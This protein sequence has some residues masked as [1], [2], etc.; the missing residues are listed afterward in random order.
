[1]PRPDHAGPP[2]KVVDHLIDVHE[3]NDTL[4]RLL[5]SG[6]GEKVSAQ[7]IRPV[8]YLTGDVGDGWQP[9]VWDGGDTVR[10]LTSADWDLTFA[11][12]GAYGGFTAFEGNV[13][14]TAE[15]PVNGL[16]LRRFDGT[17]VHLVD[18]GVG[19]SQAGLMGGFIEHDGALYFTAD[20]P[21]NG[22]E[23]RK[24]DGD[25]VTLVADIHKGPRDSQAG[26]FGGFIE[27]D[28]DLYFTA[29]DG[30]GFKL[31]RYDGT[32][33]TTVDIAGATNPGSIG[34][35]IEFDG[36]LYFTATDFVHGYELRQWDGTT[37]T[38]FD[39]NEGTRHSSAG[40]GFGFF[41][42][43]GAL[44]FKAR[45][46]EGLQLYQ[47]DDTGL[48]VARAF[49]DL[50]SVGQNGFIEFD[51]NLYF[52]ALDFDTGSELRKYDG[53]SIHTIDI[54]PQGGSQAGSYGGYVEFAGDLWF[55]A[56]DPV[57]GNEL[58]RLIGG[59]EDEVQT[60][61]FLPGSGNSD[62]QPLGV[63]NGS[64]AIGARID[65]DGDGDADR[66]AMLAT[67][68]RPQTVD[69]FYIVDDAGGTFQPGQLLHVTDTDLLA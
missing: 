49:S 6:I 17:T 54:N 15:D 2:E 65:E 52:T 62:A 11:S 58:R 31:H 9:W 19:P 12:T 7:L 26:T 20:D 8:G 24:L 68:V 37:V 57:H 56:Y 47:L 39:I 45:G 4:E 48:S 66:Y 50:R 35:F 63:V 18:I 14:F 43:D 1:M 3:R 46:D 51:G 67:A 33:V 13:Y 42:F 29:D 25:G 61:D 59:S 28:G 23:L 40:Q 21:I 55:T 5:A 10:L 38:T 16:E 32:A 60:F 27:Y 34:G 44:Y 53:T 36:K 22:F 30:G 69:D 64:L 41:E